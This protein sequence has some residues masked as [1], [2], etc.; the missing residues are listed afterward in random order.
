MDELISVGDE[1]TYRDE[2][3]RLT[4]WCSVNN[5]RL[6]TTKT[7]ELIL[8][9]HKRSTDLTPMIINGVCVERVHTFKF[10]GIHIT[11]NLYW[12]ANTVMVL[13]KVQM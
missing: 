7:K 12:T 2:V 1:F 11:D 5:L 13:K 6:N 10:L 9:L 8:D 4:E 3:E